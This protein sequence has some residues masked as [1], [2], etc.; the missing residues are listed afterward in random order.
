MLHKGCRATERGRTFE[1]FLDQQFDAVITVC[2]Q[3]N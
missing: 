3:A 1:K 2:D